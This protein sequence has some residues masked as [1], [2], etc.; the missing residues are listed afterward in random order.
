MQTGLLPLNKD[1][2]TVSLWLITPTD[3]PAASVVRVS[4]GSSKSGAN[5]P[6]LTSGLSAPRAGLVRVCS[7]ER[8]AVEGTWNSMATSAGTERT[9]A[10]R[11]AL[12]ISLTSIGLI[13]HS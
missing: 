8:A 10:S 1:N 11:P 6:G 5:S 7:A 12:R 2:L 4:L 3:L 13:A 9:V